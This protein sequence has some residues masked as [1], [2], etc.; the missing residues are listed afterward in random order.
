VYQFLLKIRTQFYLWGLKLH[1]LRSKGMLP[2]SWKTA[3]ILFPTLLALAVLPL[4][5]ILPHQARK[6][7]RQQFGIGGPPIYKTQLYTIKEKESLWQIAK[8]NN[9]RFDTIVTAN[10]MKSVHMIR[11]GQQL[12]IPNQDGILYTVKSGE[13]IFSVAEKFQVG[14]E[15]ILDVNDLSLSCTN[16]VLANRDIFIPGAK[17]SSDERMGLLGMDFFRPTQAKI[18]SGFGWRT[19]PLTGSR[20]YHSGVDFACGTGTP[21][22][23]AAD[24]QVIFSGD[25]GG[26]GISVFLRHRSGYTTVYAHLSRLN[27]V[28]GQFVKAGEVIAFSGNTG[29]STGPHLHFE[30]RKYGVPVNPLDV[31]AFFAKH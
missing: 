13:T 9:L 7:M 21:V 6:I 25:R 30:V 8:R 10:K 24:G 19:D 31:A 2:P 1:L 3:K 16:D 5:I 18:R 29:R 14:L 17:L 28:H 20:Q 11:P 26:Y 23:A 22:K 4:L 12:Y 15:D 27:V